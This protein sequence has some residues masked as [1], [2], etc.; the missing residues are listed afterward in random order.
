MLNRKAV[1]LS[2]RFYLIVEANFIDL[3][4]YEFISRTLIE[5]C[6]AYTVTK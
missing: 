1:V 4:D 6:I 5:L 2:N 3:I